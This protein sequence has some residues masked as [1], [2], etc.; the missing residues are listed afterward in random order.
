MTARRDVV[1][2]SALVFLGL[3]QMVADLTGLPAVRGLAAATL[4]SPAPRVFSAV[5]GLETYSTRFFL[6]WDHRTGRPH[7]VEIT[8]EIAARLRGPYTRRNVFGAALAY[9]PVLA[10]T[11][12]TK[13]LLDAILRSGLC[14]G[15]PLLHELG[16]DP[17]DDP[18][19]V[20]VRFEPLPGTTMG[21]LPRVIEAPCP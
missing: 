13:P 9:G 14:G 2:G 16:L 20:R 4:A 3:T 21:D 11:P 6:E 15:R 18:R 5:R 1:V 7:R 8:R 19:R 17:G 12:Q 10:T